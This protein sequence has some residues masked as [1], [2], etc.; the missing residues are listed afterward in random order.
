MS[1]ACLLIIIIIIMVFIN[2][3]N[4][5]VLLK[6]AMKSFLQLVSCSGG[7]PLV[8]EMWGEDTT[9]LNRMTVT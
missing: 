7:N 1:G 8:S 6:A 3:H 2:R 5:T 4:I 9:K